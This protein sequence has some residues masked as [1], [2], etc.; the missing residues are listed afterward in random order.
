MLSGPGA[1]YG[2]RFLISLSMSASSIGARKNE[3]R[4]LIARNCF[5]SFPVSGILFDSLLSIEQICIFK[6]R[7]MSAGLVNIFL[8]IIV[9]WWNAISYFCSTLMICVAKFACKNFDNYLASQN[10]TRSLP[11]W[12]IS[13]AFFH[14]WYTGC[15]KNLTF[16]WVFSYTIYFCVWYLF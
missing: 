13:G 4:M 6:V 5:Y 3:S 15:I 16:W 1:L 2:A 9:S 11:L 8:R 14:S 10:N 12:Y 7:A